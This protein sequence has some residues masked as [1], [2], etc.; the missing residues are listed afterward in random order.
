MCTRSFVWELQNWLFFTGWHTH[1]H[2]RT[3][4]KKKTFFAFSHFG[5]P[6]GSCF[7]CPVFLVFAF[8]LW[9]SACSRSTHRSWR[10]F[11]RSPPPSPTSSS[12]PSS[13]SF[14]MLLHRPRRIKKSL[15]I[16]HPE[17]RRRSRHVPRQC[18]LPIIIFVLCLIMAFLRPRLVYSSYKCARARTQSTRP[19]HF[20]IKFKQTK[21]KKVS[22][23]GRT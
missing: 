3:Q 15:R 22:F 23:Q 21:G 16:C 19:T 6:T 11:S 12:P 5:G 2:A 17:G 7:Y 8:F 14:P 9:Q 1:T 13:T 20:T 10:Q 4:L 18:K